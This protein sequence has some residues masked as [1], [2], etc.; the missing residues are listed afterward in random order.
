[1]RHI[2]RSFAAADATGGGDPVISIDGVDATNVSTPRASESLPIVASAR[3]RL[4]L[5]CSGKKSPT[6]A[7]VGLGSGEGGE[8][9][10]HGGWRLIQARRRH[11]EDPARAVVSRE[12]AISVSFMF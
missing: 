6:R 9:G 7:R 8:R 5:C 11:W 10:E 1:M 2:A 3:V 4:P 12:L